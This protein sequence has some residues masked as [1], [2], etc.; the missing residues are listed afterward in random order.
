MAVH[1]STDS[2]SVALL[3][4]CHLRAQVTLPSAPPL[5]AA[6]LALAFAS[7]ASS[8]ALTPLAL[9]GAAVA[10]D[11]LMARRDEDVLACGTGL[12][13]ALQSALQEGGWQSHALVERIQGLLQE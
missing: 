6:Q 13:G 9:A 11:V 10:A 3:T 8:S 2:A 12:L 7:L 4:A 5:H 1:A